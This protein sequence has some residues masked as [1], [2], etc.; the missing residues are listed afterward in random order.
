MKTLFLLLFSI[1]ISLNSYAAEADSETL[2]AHGYVSNLPECEGGQDSYRTNCVGTYKW[3]DGWEYFGEWKANKRHGIGIFYFKNPDE[4][5]FGE[6][7]NDAFSGSGIT[8]Y[9]DG[10][11]WAGVWKNDRVNGLGIYVEDG[12]VEQGIYNDGKFQSVKRYLPKNATA[13]SLTEFDYWSWNCNNGYVR[14]KNYI[15]LKSNSETSTFLSSENTSIIPTN[16]H[17]VGNGWTCD[18]NFY[19]N[20]SETA[21]LTVPAMSTSTYNSNSFKCNTGYIKTGDYC[22]RVPK[23]SKASGSSWICNYNYY[24]KTSSSKTCTK[25]PINSTSSSLSNDYKCNTGYKKSGNKCIP[26]LVIPKNAKASG[27]SFMCNNGYYKNSSTTGCLKVPA[28]AKKRSNDKGW[29]CN[30]GYTKTG[31]SCTNTAELKRIEE[32]KKIAQAKA[33]KVLKAAQLDAR[34]YYNDLEAFLKTN[35]KEYDTRKI[36]ELR[37]QNKVILTQPWDAVLARNFAELKSFTATSKAF[38][39]YHQLRN[40]ARQR[41]ILNELDKANTRLKNISA[42][43]NYYVDNNFTSDITLEVLDQIDIATAGLKKQ[44]LD[45]LIKVSTQLENFIANN[46]L[47]NDFKAFSKAIAQS[48]PD[49]PEEV[50]QKIDATDLLT[51]D[52]M[53]KA[54]RGDYLA[55]INLTG[56]APNALLNLEGDVVFENDRA[57]SCFY[58]SKNTIKNDLK[59][60]L[61]DTFSNKEFLV[62]D[63]GFECKQNNLL[64]YDLVFFEK[65]TLVKE[66]ESYVASLAAAIAYNELQP[67]KI[68]TKQQRSKDFDSRKDKVADIIEG[69]EEEMLVGFGAVVI[70]NDNTTLCTDVKNTLGQASIMRLLSNEFTRMG[71]GKSVS[72]TAFN[73]AEDTFANVQRDRCGFIYAGEETLANLL[74]AFKSSG[75]KYDVL[76]VWYSK[77]MVKKEQLRQEGKEQS[78]LIEDQKAKEQKDKAKELARL[79]AEAELK[80][81]KASGVL[82]VAE[83]KRLQARNRNDV[84]AHVQLI[85]KEAKLLLD[86]DPSNTGPVLSLYPSLVD[87][88]NKKLKEGWELDNFSVEINDYGL[89]SFRNRMIETFITDINFKLKNRVLGEYELSCARVAIIDDQE[90]EMLREPKLGGCKPG[91]LDSYKKKLDFQSNWLVQ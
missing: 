30:S 50:V 60:Y 2:I 84:E 25:V 65:G 3:Q 44:S 13:T 78:E 71:Y 32:A 37:K 19:R 58:Q 15:C 35:T 47:A 91:S 80:A 68:I 55:L 28:F 5:Y 8:T 73:S 54:N 52:F 46:K 14:I 24:K 42:Y 87:F 23:N 59:Y 70:D 26:K 36:L 81:L 38:R 33:A 63:R 75:T 29:V 6:S 53:K 64:D 39:D 17:K 85:E 88:M 90:F 61:Y 77:K 67:F 51:F 48:A 45:G 10:A 49:E 16:S 89:G 69:L 41:A 22:K 43:L 57:L 12:F 27:S 20:K 40:D 9:P 34:N 18:T 7:I 82:K 76:P 4:E 66:S 86:K 74:N 1:L 56:K 21:C 11:V 72:N 62:M 31:T 83:Q 79:R